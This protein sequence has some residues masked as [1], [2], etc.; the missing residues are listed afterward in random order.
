ML[1]Q[2]KNTPLIMG[3]ITRFSATS[4]SS[5]AMFNLYLDQSR[6]SKQERKKRA[7]E[8]EILIGYAKGIKSE[9]A[10]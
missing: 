8:S 10:E 1:V 3:S 5:V 7:E 6:N 9:M 2:N 4:M